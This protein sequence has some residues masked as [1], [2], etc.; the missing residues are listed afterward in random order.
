M[1]SAG[2]A[3]YGTF[4]SAVLRPDER[5]GGRN[6]RLA[7]D[8]TNVQHKQ[9]HFIWQFSLIAEEKRMHSH[10][11]KTLSRVSATGSAGI[12]AGCRCLPRMRPSLRRRRPSRIRRR[13]G[14][15]LP[16]TVTWRRREPVEVLQPDGVTTLPSQY[17]SITTESSSA[18]LTSSTSMLAPRWRLRP[19]TRL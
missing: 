7:R 16:A 12:G 18:A 19:T 14:I 2:N 17:K 1:C 6:E 4:S 9:N 13:A 8:R 15:S 5:S 3:A 11:L 10:V